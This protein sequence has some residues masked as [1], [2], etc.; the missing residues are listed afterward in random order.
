MKLYDIFKMLNHN[1]INLKQIL[2]NYISNDWNDIIKNIKIEDCNN[3]KYY[4]L[5]I[6]N[7]DIAEV[8]LIKWFENA[9]TYIHDHPKQCIVK[10]LDGSLIEYVYDRI[11]NKSKLLK[12]NN[13]HKNDIT[14]KSGNMILHKIKCQSHC[15]SLHIYSPIKFINNIYY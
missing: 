14:T 11:D 7:N 8:Y 9:E 15:V 13:L 12:I 3:N 2:E 10:I 6:F 1:D 5:K 4:K